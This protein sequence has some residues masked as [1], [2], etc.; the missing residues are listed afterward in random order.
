MRLLEFYRSRTEGVKKIQNDLLTRFIV[1]LPEAEMTDSNRLLYHILQAQWF[2]FKHYYSSGASATSYDTGKEVSKLYEFGQ[3]LLGGK[4]NFHYTMQDIRNF[5]RNYY[6]QIPVCGAIIFH[7]EKW[8]IVR[9]GWAKRFGFPKGKI[10]HNESDNDCAI[11]E[12][13]EETGIDIRPFLNKDRFIE[14]QSKNRRVKFFI[15]HLPATFSAPIHIQDTSEIAECKWSPVSSSVSSLLFLD[16][17][18]RAVSLL[19]PPP[20]AAA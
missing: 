12:V 17:S 18:R 9:S 3:W 13:K 2:F 5:F 10:N 15:V 4:D 14:F 8:L 6:Y 20:I 7:Q 16:D 1:N 19:P 11:R